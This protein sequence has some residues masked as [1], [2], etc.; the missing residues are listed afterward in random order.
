MVPTNE[1]ERNS[2][3]VHKHDHHL[4]IKKIKNERKAQLQL[5]NKK[6]N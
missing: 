4:L 1:K 5:K 2:L 3:S 6:N